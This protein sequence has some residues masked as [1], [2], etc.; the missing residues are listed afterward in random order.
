RGSAF[1]IDYTDGVKRIRKPVGKT[2]EEAERA[3]DE[4]LNKSP[5]VQVVGPMVRDVFDAYW[6]KLRL[7]ARHATLCGVKSALKLL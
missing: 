4:A 7:S 2:R 1:W 3:L 6:R 5:S